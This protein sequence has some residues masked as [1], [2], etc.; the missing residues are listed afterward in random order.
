VSIPGTLYI[1]LSTKDKYP[2]CPTNEWAYIYS[3]SLR[4]DRKETYG[5]KRI[6]YVGVISSE[7]TG[8]CMLKCALHGFNEAYVKEA[9][10]QKKEKKNPF[11]EN[12]WSHLSK[13]ER[14][15][16][17]SKLKEQR[18]QA[19]RCNFI[20]KNVRETK[21]EAQ[22]RQ[23]RVHELVQTF[24]H[25][26]LSVISKRIEILELTKQHIEFEVE[27]LALKKKLKGVLTEALDEKKKLIEMS[28]QW[29][30]FIT[31]FKILADLNSDFKSAKEQLYV[32]IRASAMVKL[33]LLSHQASIVKDGD[34]IDTR[35]LTTAGR[36]CLLVAKM[37]K[38]QTNVKLKH[39]LGVFFKTAKHKISLL[40]RIERFGNV[41]SR[42]S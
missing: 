15:E 22:G 25:R 4:I 13:Q 29:I 1:Y 6:L 2:I 20:A 7:F 33:Y 27:K 21:H 37:Y 23:H 14:D 11:A 42:D 18:K 35:M 28:K 10:R 16:E 31:L 12:P 34:D 40:R 30:K 3:G 26:K 5:D 9:L 41:S 32:S 38:E 17:I 8:V 39:V 36:G 24:E 19:H